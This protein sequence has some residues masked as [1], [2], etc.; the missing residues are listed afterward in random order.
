MDDNIKRFYHL[1]HNMEYIVKTP[2]FFRYMED[3]TDR[4]TN[5]ALSGP[6]YNNRVFRKSAKVK[7]LKWGANPA[8][9]ILI[10]NHIPYRF[11]TRANE[12]QDLMIQVLKGGWCTLIFNAF[13]Q[14]KMAH[15]QIKGG[16]TEE[17]NKGAL[18]YG[19]K[20]MLMLHPDV[21]RLES[22]GRLRCRYSM[23]KNHPIKNHPKTIEKLGQLPP[24]EL[25]EAD[26]E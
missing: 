9:C 24:L 3:F 4:Y 17:Y 23:F 25:V 13:L 5:I 6:A 22:N 10:N 15:R 19:W 12:D 11:R 7:P 18:D 8:S 16:L 26:S 1:S 14:D 2:L 21:C 20:Q